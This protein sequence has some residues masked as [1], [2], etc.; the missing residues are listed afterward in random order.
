MS[1]LN[2]LIKTPST[3]RALTYSELADL[4]QAV[5]TFSAED[6]WPSELGYRVTLVIDE[7]VQNVIDYGYEDH[8]AS[9]S[10]F[11]DSDTERIVIEIIDSG[12]PFDPLTEAPE[13][14]ISSAIEDRPIGGLGVFFVRTL[15]D[16]VTYQRDSNRN[17]LTMMVHKNQ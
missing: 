6:D 1:T 8:E 4:V 16:E 2:L 12:K 13:P 9:A 17:H 10:V 15:M 14:D 7:L 11:I 3:E 5:E